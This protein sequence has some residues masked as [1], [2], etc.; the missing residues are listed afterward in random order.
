MVSCVSN[1]HESIKNVIHD[2]LQG[3]SE[4]TLAAFPNGPSL[5]HCVQ[6]ARH[7]QNHAPPIPVQLQGFNIPD[8]YSKLLP[9]ILFLQCDSGRD[10][11]EHILIFG[12]EDNLDLLLR[13]RH[14]LADGTFKCLPAVFYQSFTLHVYIEGSVVPA[15]YAL[16]SNKT[17]QTY[18]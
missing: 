2:A 12:F 9:G 5:S 17:Q 3:C 13:H 11:A 15:V 6:R 18:Q 14:W 4:N 16:L 8:K 1:R 10:D 7:K